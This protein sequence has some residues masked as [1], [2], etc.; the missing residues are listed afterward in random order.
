MIWV[1]LAKVASIYDRT[2]V[3]TFKIKGVDAYWS[4]TC[5]NQFSLNLTKDSWYWFK[6]EFVSKGDSYFHRNSQTWAKYSNSNIFILEAL[7][8]S[9][10]N[11]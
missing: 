3:I 5:L 8:N 7:P 9:N 2:V 10:S 1:G 6:L 11:F 4:Y